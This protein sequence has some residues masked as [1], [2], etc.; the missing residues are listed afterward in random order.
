MYVV[1]YVTMV[2]VAFDH[3]HMRDFVTRRVCSETLLLR[4]MWGGGLV[5]PDLP[6]KPRDVHPCTPFPLRT[7]VSTPSLSCPCGFLSCTVYALLDLL[8]ISRTFW[9]ANLIL[10]STKRLFLEVLS[11]W[12]RQQTERLLINFFELLEWVLYGFFSSLFMF[13]S[14]DNR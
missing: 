13:S 1:K 10:F 3:A 8:S 5:H 11:L 6:Q 9:F 14:V 4:G 7:L 12:W 2:S